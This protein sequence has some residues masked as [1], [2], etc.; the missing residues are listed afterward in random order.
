MRTHRCGWLA[1]VAWTLL[2][3]TSFAIQNN[4]VIICN[5]E[6]RDRQRSALLNLR[7]TLGVNSGRLQAW[8]VAADHC[9]WDGVFCCVAPSVVQFQ[10][11]HAQQDCRDRWQ[12]PRHD[13]LYIPWMVS[14]PY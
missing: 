2:W 6:C 10:A 4:T 9:S 5:A 1:L 14:R 7:D 13:L 12:A 3:W 11:S 8:D